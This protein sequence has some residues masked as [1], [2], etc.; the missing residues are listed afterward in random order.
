[1]EAGVCKWEVDCVGRWRGQALTEGA[2]PE[3]TG[4]EGRDEVGRV[5][6]LEGM[7]GKRPGREKEERCPEWMVKE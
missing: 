3:V 5:I 1:M 6:K 7:E 2:S 4:M